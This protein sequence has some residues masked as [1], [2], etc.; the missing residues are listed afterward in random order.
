MIN[1]SQVKD[2]KT[3]LNYRQQLFLEGY[4]KTGNASDAA[5]K[6]GYAHSQQ[7]GARLLTNVV[8]QAKIKER[9]G[10]KAMEADEVLIRLAEQARMNISMFVRKETFTNADGY[11]ESRLSLNWDAIE[12]HGYLVKSITATAHGPKIEL[13]DGQTALIH[14]GKHHKLFTEKQEISTYSKVAFRIIE[15]DSV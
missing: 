2:P 5:R 12:E 11:E 15:D 14:I 7:S 3:G 8:I 1:K 6:A 4:L 9:V 10:V 13:Y